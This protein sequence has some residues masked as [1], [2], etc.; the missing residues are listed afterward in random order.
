MHF[1]PHCNTG[2]QE[3]ILQAREIYLLKQTRCI[4]DLHIVG[5]I[6]QI[7]FQINIAYRNDLM[8]EL[9]KISFN[10]PEE[11]DVFFQFGMLNP[12]PI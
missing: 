6:T 3:M 8:I 2:I 5:R 11:L 10:L 9:H 1:T 12:I 4:I 7:E